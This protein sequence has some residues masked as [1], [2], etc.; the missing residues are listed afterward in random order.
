VGGHGRQEPEL[1]ADFGAILSFYERLKD[2]CD[3][4]GKNLFFVSNGDWAHGTGLTAPGDPS[5]FLPILEK[6]PWDALNC[7]NHELY[8]NAKV[9]S[10]IKPGGF[11]DW[12]GDR[13]LTSNILTAE[14]GRS[15][16]NQFIILEGQNNARVLT[17]G[18][19]YNMQ[20]SCD[21]VEVA[22][23][24][25]V[26][27]S[28]WFLDALKTNVYDA[29]L[30][31]AHMD[32]DDPLVT[33]I[34]KAIRDA[35]GPN[36]PI[37]FITGHTHYRGQTQLDQ[38]SI[39]FEAGRYL[40][41]VGFV[42]FP[43]HDGI[44]EKMEQM[45][46]MDSLFDSLFQ[47]VFIDANVKT[48]AVWL[49][50]DV[51]DFWTETGTELTD[52]IQK[53]REK[54]GLT[55]KIGCAPHDFFLDLHVDDPKSLYG[56]YRDQVV[57]KMF[58]TPEDSIVMFVPTES[59]RYNLISRSDLI[60]DDV[61][62]VSPFNDTITLLGIF[63]GADIL[64][65][66][67]TLNV[68]TSDKV[69]LVPEY[70]LIGDIGDRKTEYKLYTH[71]FVSEKIAAELLKI[72]PNAAIEA[73]PT[74]ITSTLLW[75]SFVM[76]EWPC[77]GL[78]A[79]LPGWFSTPGKISNQLDRPDHGIAMEDTTVIMIVLASSI[80]CALLMLCRG[81]LKSILRIRWSGQSEELKSFKGPWESRGANS[82]DDGI[83]LDESAGFS[84]E[85][86]D[87]HEML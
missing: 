48:L 75:I 19:L 71:D 7:G 78:T 50:I 84:S 44:V 31:L 29:I 60:I 1:D 41:T 9:A 4:V 51:D 40:D 64:K 83:L 5:S 16:G 8:E 18:F 65:L 2:H 49:G 10:M 21:M 32:K 86:P 73:V 74:E 26:V 11:V 3:K 61:W 55:E 36:F 33:V 62:A 87:E 67:E 76:E 68:A 13:Y 80:V 47:G 53:T 46:N 54:T 69:V 30:V 82:D 12:F 42:S 39:S 15:M 17:F 57:P 77:D 72:D 28:E 24:E 37:Q 45:T 63:A 43:T 81:N 85:L 20:D 35:V 70:L 52:F 25:E 23:V 27:E 6:M 58:F 22:R 59:F 66:N 79:K 56:L 38:F 14:D 34:L